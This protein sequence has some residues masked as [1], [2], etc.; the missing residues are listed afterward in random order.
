MRDVASPFNKCTT[1]RTGTSG[2]GSPPDAYPAYEKSGTR[3]PRASMLDCKPSL[4]AITGD[5]FLLDCA[6]R[7]R[8]GRKAERSNKTTHA[9]DVCNEK[10]SLYTAHFFLLIGFQL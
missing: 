1:T 2:I 7:G 5:V 6:V 10:Q 8:H 9:P 3:F 4:V